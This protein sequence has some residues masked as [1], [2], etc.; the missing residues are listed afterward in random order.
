MVLSFSIPVRN[1]LL[2][3]SSSRF[4]SLVL[5]LTILSTSSSVI[6]ILIMPVRPGASPGLEP[7]F[8]FTLVALSISSIPPN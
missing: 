5:P 6:S 8:M 3:I 2:T 7:R 4:A 1:Q